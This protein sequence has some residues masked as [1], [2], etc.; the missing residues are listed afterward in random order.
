[1]S[2][3]ALL[4]PA[5]VSLA[6]ALLTGLASAAG[7]ARSG[8]QVDAKVPGPFLAYNVNGPDAGKK[9]C[10]YCRNGMRPAVM[11]FAREISPA[12]VALLK[13]VDAAAAADPEHRLGGYAIF[14]SDNEQLP[15]QLA[16]LAAQE[17]LTHVF[18][19]TFASAGPPRYAIAADADVTGVLY[20]RCTV[21]AN[22]AFK[23][24]ELTAPE[25][26]RVLSDLPKILTQD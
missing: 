24:G 15:A 3:R 23:R 25:I 13:R 5:A 21:K 19:A 6:A 18:L 9:A 11:I 8:P 7:T 14:C 12:L 17:K 16:Q 1:M 4:R 22:H 10:L 26:D 2:P 20:T